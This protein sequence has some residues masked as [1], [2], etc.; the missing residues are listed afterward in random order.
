MT[1]GADRGAAVKS[2]EWLAAERT[3]GV[4][5][6]SFSPIAA[7]N[8]SSNYKAVAAGGR[9]YFVKFAPPRSLD[10][11][12]RRA[13]AVISPLVPALAFGGAVGECGDLRF[14]AFE[15]IGRG[16]VVDPAEFSA[17]RCA[18]L[19]SAYDAFSRSL[20]AA[21]ADLR[22]PDDLDGFG[23]DVRA[24]HGDLHCRNLVFDG[25]DVVA[26][27]DL[28]KM[29]IGHPTEDLLKLFVHAL[30][31][32]R[33]WRRGRIAAIERAFGELVRQSAFELDA[34][35]A[36]ISL[37]ERRKSARRSQKS[38]LP[39]LKRVEAV[40]RA[41]LYRRLREIAVEANVLGRGSQEASP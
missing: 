7:G 14:C 5:F 32:T 6:S 21:A 22:R 23:G 30:E 13:L 11:V 8:S 37:H 34:W 28:E 41:P 36:A 40:F 3:F 16:T 24:V 15:W 35:L 20:Q 38:R 9:A 27:F 29:R 26:F 39:V 17:A 33:F 10:V 31:R 25:D 4:G 2:A 12:V 1:D 19:L 18:S